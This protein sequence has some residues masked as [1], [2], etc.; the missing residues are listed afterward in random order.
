MRATQL[1]PTPRALTRAICGQISSFFNGRITSA[2]ESAAD[3]LEVQAR[4][5]DADEE[6]ALGTGAQEIATIRDIAGRVAAAFCEGL[7][8]DVEKALLFQDESARS[9]ADTT[10]RRRALSTHGLEVSLLSD[11]ELELSVMVS[12]VASRFERRNREALERIIEPIERG[13]GEDQAERLRLL[14]GVM[15]L[16]NRFST[17]MAGVA[18]SVPTRSRLM[19]AFQFHV[20]EELKDFYVPLA[21]GLQ[22]VPAGRS[23]GKEGGPGSQAAA[24]PAPGGHGGVGQAPAGLAGWVQL[25]GQA[26]AGGAGGAYRSGAARGA[27]AVSHDDFVASLTELPVM[28]VSAPEDEDSSATLY[29]QVIDNLQQQHGLLANQLPAMDLNVLR[30]VSLFFETFLGDDSLP[31]ALRFLVGRLQLPIL[32]LALADGSFFDDYDHPAR[33]LIETLCSIGVGWSSDLAWVE[34]SPAFKE[35]NALIDDILDHASPDA[36]V[37]EDAVSRLNA[38]HADRMEKA[39]RVEGRVVELE[40]GRAKLRAAKLVVQDALNEQLCRHRSLVPLQWFFVDAWSKVLVFI[41][42]RHGCQGEEWQAAMDMCTELAEVLTPAASR[43]E[44]KQR[45]TRV[46]NLLERLE[47]RMV[48]A[49]FTSN[50]VDQSIEK[51]Y[52][53]IDRIR[54]S[55]DDWFADAGEMVIEQQEEIEPITLLP[56]PPPAPAEGAAEVPEWVRSGA[57]V[58]VH[59]ADDPAR[60]HQVKVAARVTDTSEILLVDER[61]A[62]WGIWSE[63]DLLAALEEGRVVQVANDDVVQKTLDAMIAQ[64]TRDTRMPGRSGISAG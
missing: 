56:A 63:R 44:S 33:K 8:A 12:T 10:G 61:G 64:L 60:Y 15:G 13:Y 38:M 1:A 57:W 7:Q 49:G 27:P 23:A 21:Q 3:E 14:I 32:R 36:A 4:V 31:T 51:L 53:E 59:D 55:E 11:E 39:D 18:L 17:L 50:A 54:E 45:F 28:D 25:M 19:N 6:D 26:Q 48:E 41:C 5:D 46:P 47:S 29:D 42:L 30:L 2:L 43:S 16:I 20:L 52:S 34:R 62:R 58:R 35:V 37:F 22:G 40:V 9:T 24:G